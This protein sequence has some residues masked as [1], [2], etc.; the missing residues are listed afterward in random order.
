MFKNPRRTCPVQRGHLNSPHYLPGLDSLNSWKPKAVASV[1]RTTSVM[2]RCSIPCCWCHCGRSSWWFFRCEG[3]GSFLIVLCVAMDNP[4]RKWFKPPN[5]TFIHPFLLFGYKELFP[6][7]HREKKN[8]SIVHILSSNTALLSNSSGFGLV[9][10]T[11][12]NSLL[13]NDEFMR[14]FF[15]IWHPGS[16]PH[17][18]MGNVSIMLNHKERGQILYQHP[19]KMPLWSYAHCCNTS[20][21]NLHTVVPT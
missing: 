1:T 5:L 7:R 9:K 4:C 13:P 6:P 15:L 14:L 11:V 17:D 16:R 19:F 2:K 12:S 21:I 8:F 3:R 20:P 18:F 10:V